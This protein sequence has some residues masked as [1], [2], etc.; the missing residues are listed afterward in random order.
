MSTSLVYGLNC[1][2]FGCVF[3]SISAKLRPC[4]IITHG[5]GS[6]TKLNLSHF[7]LNILLTNCIRLGERTVAPILFCCL[8]EIHSYSG[9][10]KWI[11]FLYTLSLI[12]NGIIIWLRSIEAEISSDCHLPIYGIIR[13][14]SFDV[15][16]GRY[17]SRPRLLSITRHLSSR[18][19]Y[20][21]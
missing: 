5:M 4:L 3:F 19:C 20:P 10:M 8:A 6:R 16:H 12:C 21:F 17:S 7:N 11:Y 14:K 18:Y 13:E 15:Y 2:H 1:C 9:L